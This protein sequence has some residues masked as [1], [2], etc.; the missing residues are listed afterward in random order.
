MTEKCND[1]EKYV[2]TESNQVILVRMQAEKNV[3]NMC[4][5]HPGSWGGQ[6][7]EK[8]EKVPL[9]KHARIFVLKEGRVIQ[10]TEICSTKS[11]Q[12]DT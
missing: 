1:S 3:R 6:A 11:S 9:K 7:R 8:Y 5:L 12:V 2:K 10:L 4:F